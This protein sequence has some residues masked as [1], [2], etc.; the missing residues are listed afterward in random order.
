MTSLMA[1][2]GIGV[3]RIAGSPPCAVFQHV[4]GKPEVRLHLQSSE[5]IAGRFASFAGDTVKIET[6]TGLV[7]AN[8]QNFDSIWVRGTKWKPGAIAGGVATGLLV[9][10]VW[11]S[12]CAEADNS[13][14]CNPLP[15]ALESAVFGSL[16]GVVIGG[17][18]GG[19]F[20]QWQRRYP[21]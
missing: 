12:F 10:W 20:P 11:A 5:T 3:F 7:S 9:G 15:L 4:V 6:P 21:P 14:G 13:D 1:L 17:L 8:C 18:I 19:A 16:P 2:V